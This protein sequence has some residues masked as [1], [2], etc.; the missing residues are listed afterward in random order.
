MHTLTRLHKNKEYFSNAP[1]TI[2]KAKKEIEK[3]LEIINSIDRPIIAFFGSARADAKNENYQHARALGKRLGQNGYAILTGG[4][5]GIL[6]AANAGAMDAEAPS[7][8]FQAELLTREQVRDTLFTHKYPFHFIFARRFAMSIKSE[9]LIFYP[10]G[11]G[12]LN[13]LFEY[14]MLMQTGIVDRVP[15][16]CVGKKYWSG[17]FKWMKKEVL[18]N[19]YLIHPKDFDLITLL[20]REEEIIRFIE[21]HQK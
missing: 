20:D 4:G 21:T 18:E 12:T 19:D 14:A 5:P 7:I 11:L 16:I 8:G 1:Q 13:E 6:Y 17:L 15:L 10:G 2:E 3:G 9:A